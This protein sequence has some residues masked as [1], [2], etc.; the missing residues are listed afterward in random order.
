[1]VLTL[2]VRLDR[3]DAFRELCGRLGIHIRYTELGHGKAA[4]TMQFAVRADEPEQAM[5]VVAFAFDRR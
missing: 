1:M 5:A 3:A 2:A 4:D